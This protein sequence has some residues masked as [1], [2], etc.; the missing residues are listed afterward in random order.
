MK[1]VVGLGNPGERYANTRHNVGFWVLDLLAKQ[2][3]VIGWQQKFDGLIADCQM[4]DRVYLLK[5][6]TFMNRS[7]ISVRK[8]VDFFK[9][10]P[11]DLM[12][13]CDD[14]SLPVGSI[15]IRAKGSSGGQNGLKDIVANLGTEEIPRLRI[16]IGDRK[17]MDA[18]TF[19]LSSF[20]EKRD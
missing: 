18:A 13:V 3:Q 5:P 6:M 9:V 10:E 4:G 16:G 2:N 12:V 1:V 11:K 15:R 8:L 17:Q 14:L 19:V 7:G 20:K